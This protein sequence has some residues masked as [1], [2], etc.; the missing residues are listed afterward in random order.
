MVMGGEWAQRCPVRPLCRP[1]MLRLPLECLPFTHDG[2]HQ[3]RKNEQYAEALRA[4]QRC[5]TSHQSWGTFLT[6]M[7]P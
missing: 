4:S 1:G 2:C 3:A 5:I 7:K 6:C